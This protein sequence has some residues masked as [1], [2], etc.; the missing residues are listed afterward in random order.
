MSIKL[1]NNLIKD[2]LAEFK[3]NQ[4]RGRRGDIVKKLDYYTGCE[5]GGYIEDRFKNSTFQEI[6]VYESN[7]TKKFIN[8]ISRNYTV[9]AERNINATYNNLTQYKNFK[10]KHIERMT[11]LLGT[12]AIQ[13]V[14]RNKGDNS[15]F[16]YQPVYYFDI[17]TDPSDPFTPLAI[18]YP[19]MNS[20]NDITVTDNMPYVYWDD[21]QYIE[22]NEEGEI[23][24]EVNHGYGIL[25]FVFTHKEAQTDAFFVEGANDIVNCNEHLNIAMTELMLGL[26]F[27]MFGQPFAIG[28]Y[29]DQP[30]AR[31]GTD[32]IIN[33]PE[34]AQF[35]IT[36]PQGNVDS[37]IKAL[38]FQVELVAQNNHLWVSWAEEGDR[39]ASG[40]SLMIRD[41]ERMEDM[42]D[43]V[44][45]WRIFEH[46]CYEVEK[47]IANF[48]GVNLP[49][50]FNIN[51]EEPYY[52]RAV[53]DQIMLDN[54]KLERGHITDAEIMV[55][56]NRDL[57]IKQAEKIIEKNKSINGLQPQTLEDNSNG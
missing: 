25:P 36:A 24:K 32:T 12:V 49:D 21:T 54:W 35:G 44:E 51:F 52:P 47:A 37:V 16:D 8:K 56:E 55:R 57:S 42:K 14:W 6:P 27:Q 46:Q 10:W 1:S 40:I 28:V 38:K 17:I 13:V 9:F 34:G 2:A 15:Y 4:S 5:T 20:V 31:T 22:F 19:I 33:L 18:V 39:P 41:Y 23:V 7:I 53:A 45:L 30:I 48:N 26:R 43:D 29:E 50:K 11:K 3:T